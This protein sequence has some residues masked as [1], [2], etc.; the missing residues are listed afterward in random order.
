MILRNHGLLTCGSSVAEAFFNMYMLNRACEMQV[1]A[2]CGGLENIIVPDP[3][4][5]EFT[6]EVANQFNP[7]GVGQ[8]E[9]AA[10]L[11]R[12]DSIDPSYRN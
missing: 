5:Q 4:I 12:L 11:R 8:K 6:E 9:F 10:L 2:L 3:K 7:E 1:A